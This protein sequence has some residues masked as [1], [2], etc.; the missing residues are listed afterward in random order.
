MYGTIGKSPF[1]NC[2]FLTYSHFFK[3]MR[4]I[5]KVLVIQPVLRDGRKNRVAGILSGALIPAGGKPSGT[6]HGLPVNVRVPDHAERM[7]LMLNDVIVYLWYGRRP[8]LCFPGRFGLSADP[9]SPISAG[10]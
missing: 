10:L 6:V 8:P 5:L 2:V 9:M 3:E 7:G 1:K 4:I